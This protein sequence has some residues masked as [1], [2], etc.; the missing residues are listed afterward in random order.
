MA[1]LFG[2]DG[3]RGEVGSYPLTEEAVFTI[4][5]AL[6]VWLAEQYPQQKDSLKIIVGKDTRDSGRQLELTLLKGAQLESL[7]ALRIGVCPTPAVAYLT[8]SFHAHLGVAISAS[9]NPC[10][11]NGIKFFDSDG[12]KLLSFSE[13][14]IE[15]I[16]SDLFGKSKD[17]D[18]KS[19]DLPEELNCLR[20]YTDFARTHLKERDLSHLKIVVDCAFGAFSEIAPE[21]LRGLGAEV[22]PI[23]NNPDGSNINVNC[24]TLHPEG[25]IKE[26]LARKADIA[27]AFDGDGDRVIVADEKGNIL[28][29]D[30]ILAILSQHFLKQN[31]LAGNSVICTQM[32]NLGLELYLQRQGISVIRTDVGDKHILEQMLRRNASLGGEQSGHIIMLERTTTG[33]GLIVALELIEVML[34]A[35]KSLSALGKELEKFPQTLVNIKVKEKRPFEK[36]PGLNERIKDY[37]AEL[38]ENLRILVRY[39]GTEKLARVMVEGREL[40]KISHIADSLAGIIQ[41]AVGEK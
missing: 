38:G 27:I 4:G 6:G 13:K 11:D 10:S 5:R 35:N 15:E 24:G 20:L 1:E 7:E 19:E 23:N 36:I 2:T 32:S 8:K 26:L 31:K 17:I 34:K 22:F 9:H 33:D 3:I 30:Y 29:G 40:S 37:L 21:V 12:Y 18:L 25:M 41:E 16:F 14:R 39:S 28:D